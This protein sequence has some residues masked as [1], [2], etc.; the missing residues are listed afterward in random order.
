MSHL[1]SFKM[2][3]VGTNGSE[4]EPGG[5]QCSREPW[6]PAEQKNCFL[7]RSD[8]FP[9]SLDWAR[10]TRI[11]SIIRLSYRLLSL[12]RQKIINSSISIT[13][14]HVKQDENRPL[15]SWKA[16][17]QMPNCQLIYYCLLIISVVCCG[18]HYNV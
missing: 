10:D 3:K 16:A 2:R 9:I 8:L 18:L 11:K 5:Y 12:R 1:C 14:V 17:C 6:P 15:Q 7:S 13:Y 4:A